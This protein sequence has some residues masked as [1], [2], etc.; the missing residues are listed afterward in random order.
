[1]WGPGDG[2]NIGKARRDYGL[3][4]EQFPAQFPVEKQASKIDDTPTNNMDMERL[5][6]LTDNQVKKLQNLSVA[7]RSI[8]LKKTMSIKETSDMSSFRSFKKQVEMPGAPVEPKDER[9]TQG[10]RGE[11]ADGCPWTGEE[12]TGHVGGTEGGEWPVH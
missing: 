4:E 12:E 1:M 7:S 6:G 8:I 5:M 9:E 11:E 10:G 3:D 2:R